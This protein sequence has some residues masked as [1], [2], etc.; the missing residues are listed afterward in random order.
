MALG[1]PEDGDGSADT[2]KALC[3]RVG[4]DRASQSPPRASKAARTNAFTDAA[5]G[6]GVHAQTDPAA[7][8]G[9]GGPRTPCAIL[10]SNA[11]YS[12]G[13]PCRGPPRHG[14]PTN[15]A[16]FRPPGGGLFSWRTRPR[17]G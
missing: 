1:E 4:L 8:I 16:A 9:N 12:D 7:A 17:S 5:K 14:A 15:L 3:R 6:R 11:D 10:S 13:A 2:S